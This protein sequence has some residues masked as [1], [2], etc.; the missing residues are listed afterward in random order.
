LSV[1]IPPLSLC[2]D[3]GAMIAGFAYHAYSAGRR[4]NLELDYRPNAPLGLREVKYRAR[5]KYER[6]AR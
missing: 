6:R 4:S 1:F 5:T 3:N 2:T